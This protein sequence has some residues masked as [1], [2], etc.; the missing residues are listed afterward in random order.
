MENPT[1][2]LD[3]FG[4][5]MAQIVQ[6]SALVYLVLEWIK[7]HFLT[8]GTLA[9]KGR[10]LITGILSVVLAF[11]VSYKVIDPLDW[12]KVVSLTI[13]SFLLSGGFQRAVKKIRPNGG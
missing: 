5:T 10:K 8:N 13:C 11:G 2:L 7:Q 12:E 4:L 6:V 1:Q 3:L 9:T